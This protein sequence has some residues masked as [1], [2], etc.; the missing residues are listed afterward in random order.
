MECFGIGR[1][2]PHE[3]VLD[4]I[5]ARDSVRAQK[6]IRDHLAAVGQR[7]TAALL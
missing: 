4:A 1:S 7:P 3:A 2:S 5:Q 6:A